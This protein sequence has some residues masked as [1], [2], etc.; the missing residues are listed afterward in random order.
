MS[1]SPTPSAAKVVVTGIGLWTGLGVDRESTWSALRA[2]CS[3]ARPLAE[4][5]SAGG[6]PA[7]GCPLLED[8]RTIGPQ[9]RTLSIVEQTATEALNDARLI[10][11]HAEPGRALIVDSD[12]VAT[13]IGLSKGCMENF[14]RLAR[15][16]RDRA[17]F[18]DGPADSWI[19]EHLCWPNAGA[20]RVAARHGLRGPCLAPVAACATGLVA[21]LQGAELIR[22][23]VCDVALAG[24]ADAS[25]QPLLLGAFRRMGVLARSDGDPTQAARPWDQARSG[26]VVGEGGAILVLERAD[27]AQARGVLPYAEVAG[28]ALG[29]DAY[30]ETTMNPDPAGLAALIGRALAQSGVSASELDYINVHGTATRINDPIECRALRLALGPH[31]DRVAC[32]ANKSQIGHLLGAAGAVE[33]AITCLAIRDGFVPPTLNLNDPDPACDL[34]GTPHTGRATPIRSALK[35]SIG[36]GGHLAAALLRQPET[37]ARRPREQ[38]YG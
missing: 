23:G 7:V 32:S 30:H 17:E 25:L 8:D 24:S 38:P 34:D 31:A 1:P 3:A 33:L 12:R 15:G 18:A 21:V 35:L 19:W 22:N 10:S 20:S 27:H 13:L 26:F 4:A 29:A 37:P 5:L 11:R 6:R 2:G 9:G 28:G 14:A 16:G 36:F